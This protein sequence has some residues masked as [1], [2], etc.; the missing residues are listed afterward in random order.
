M[1]PRSSSATASIL[2]PPR[3]IPMRNAIIRAAIIEK[4]ASEAE[5]SARGQ[6]FSGNSYQLLNPSD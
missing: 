1:A 2:V 4:A 6:H 3:S 5:K